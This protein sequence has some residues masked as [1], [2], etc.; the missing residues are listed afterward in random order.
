MSEI[1]LYT[2]VSFF[3]SLNSD[4]GASCT[5]CVRIQGSGSWVVG[6]ALR[7]EGFEG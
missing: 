4:S 7:V 5:T 1:T 6:E 3:S 2:K